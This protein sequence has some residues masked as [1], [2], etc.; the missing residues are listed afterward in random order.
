MIYTHKVS[1]VVSKLYWEA[2]HT[3][4]PGSRSRPVGSRGRAL[5]EHCFHYPVQPGR[6]EAWGTQAASA[7]WGWW[8]PVCPRRFPTTLVPSGPTHPAQTS[9]FAMIW[10]AITRR[11]PV[12]VEVFW[13]FTWEKQAVWGWQ[14]LLHLLVHPIAQDERSLLQVRAN[15][16][17][18]QAASLVPGPGA[19]AHEQW[20]GSGDRSGVVGHH[21]R[22]AL[23]EG[24]KQGLCP[25]WQCEHGQRGAPLWWA[26]KCKGRSTQSR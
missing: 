21:P 6:K 22:W 16:G 18:G 1:P 11:L 4:V 9:L 20:A 15:P 5:P 3:P 14:S 2:R 25:T 10:S 13:V 24:G 8:D 12:P 19:Q 26:G 23:E 7:V 17:F